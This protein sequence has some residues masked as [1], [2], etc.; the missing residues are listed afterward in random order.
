MLVDGCL[1][2]VAGKHGP[3]DLSLS[4]DLPTILLRGQREHDCIYLDEYQAGYA[5]TRHLLELGH[6]R[7]AV[8]HGPLTEPAVAQRIAGYEDAMREAGLASNALVLPAETSSPSNETGSGR[9]LAYVEHYSR[10]MP[11]AKAWFTREDRPTAVLGAWFTDAMLVQAAVLR[12]GLSLPDDVAL[13]AI[14]DHSL[15]PGFPIT[16]FFSSMTRFGRIV[17]EMMLEKLDNPHARLTPVVQKYELL[18]GLTT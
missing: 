4:R 1:I 6:T 12:A 16:T 2:D 17:A 9:S 13:M 15:N 18:R 10:R 14:H 11:Y 3:Y 7:V 5:A 8:A